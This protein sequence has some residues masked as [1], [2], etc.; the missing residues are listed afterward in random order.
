[1]SAYCRAHLSNQHGQATFIYTH[2]R[3]RTRMYGHRFKFTCSCLKI[4]LHMWIQQ[5]CD[6][7]NRPNPPEDMQTTHVYT[8][9]D[10]TDKLTLIWT[11][12]GFLDMTSYYCEMRGWPWAQR[13]G[14]APS[15]RHVDLVEGATSFGQGVLRPRSK[16]K[17]WAPSLSCRVPFLKPKSPDHCVTVVLFQPPSPRIPSQRGQF[18]CTYPFSANGW[19]RDSEAENPNPS[20]TPF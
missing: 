12:S 7:S 10:I 8:Q 14:Y 2:T 5:H 9:W 18:S 3:T 15:G 16:K 6:A 11:C 20:L 13:A 4:A 1:M 19:S 17:I